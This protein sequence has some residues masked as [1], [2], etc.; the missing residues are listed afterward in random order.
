MTNKFKFSLYWPFTRNAMQTLLSY[1]SNV[2]FFIL[3]NVLR[4]FVF[5]FLWKA[6]FRSSGQTV[7]HGYTFQQMVIYLI[8]TTALGE[9]RGSVGGDM[10]D[11]IK[12]GQI[13][14]SFIKPISFR[15]RIY[16]TSF[17]DTLYSLIMTGIPAL[18]AVLIIAAVYGTIGEFT[19][20]NTMLF[21]VA[22]IFSLI[23]Y[24]SYNFVFSLLGFV[25]TNMW[26]LWQ[27]NKAIVQLC[28]GAIIPLVFFPEWAQ[29]VLNV[30][31]FATLISTPISIFL[32]KCTGFELL[33]VLCM[34]A[35]WILAFTL[36]GNF[37]WGKVVKHLTV[38][39]G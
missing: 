36:L 24:M 38:Q 35:F 4:I 34:Q 32:G 12:S 7:L 30:L 3:G 37:V 27:I 18:I 31:P 23:I 21:V 5:F 6:I 13:A 15:L 16:F 39:G 26:G 25:T 1:R 11:E 8:L 9:T 17:G 2:L 20:L 14:M 10:S 28:S 29:R 33:R 19:V 22:F